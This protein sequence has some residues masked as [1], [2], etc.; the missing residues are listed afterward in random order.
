M[1]EI[2]TRRRGDTRERIQSVA[3]ERFTENGYDQTSLR[4]IAEDLGV[5]KA[6]LYHHFKTKEEI[7]DSL[8]GQVSEEIEALVTWMQSGPVTPERQLEMLGRLSDVTRGTGGGVMQCV[9]QNEVALNNLGATT[10]TVHQIK[11]RLWEASM[12]VDATVEDRLRLRMAVMAVLIANKPS[13][14]LGGT[15][16][17]RAKAAL[18]VAADL[19]H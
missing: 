10:E 9:Q 12:P 6:A 16:E 5:S 7:L 17:D 19:I 3:L 1:S 8:L 2:T 11:E 14:D 13:S 18:A 4:E 15:R